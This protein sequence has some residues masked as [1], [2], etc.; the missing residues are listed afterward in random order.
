MIHATNNLG[1][2]LLGKDDAAGIDHLRRSRA[3]ALEHHLP[4]EVGRAN[5]NLSSQGGRIFPLPY[6][7]MDRQLLEATDYAR[8]TIPDGIFDRWNRSARGEFLLMSGRW[9]EAEEVLFGLDVDVAEA[10]LRG[11]ILSLRGLLYA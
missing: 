11:E 4:D 8:R 2:C 9:E 10:Y 6:E 5:S 1:T 7:E 3:L